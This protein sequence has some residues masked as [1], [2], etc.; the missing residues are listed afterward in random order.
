VGNLPDS[1]RL[2]KEK[3]EP[4]PEKPEMAEN[5]SFETF[6]LGKNVPDSG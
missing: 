4:K 5:P 2:S 3:R 6:A 1:G